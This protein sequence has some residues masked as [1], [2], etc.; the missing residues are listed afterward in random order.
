MQLDIGNL[1]QVRTA[2]LRVAQLEERE[3]VKRSLVS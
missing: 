1:E 3:T 2:V